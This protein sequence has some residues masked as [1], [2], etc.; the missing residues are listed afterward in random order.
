V[1]K[2]A[3]KRAAVRK[4]APKKAVVKKK[5]PPRAPAVRRREK[6]QK[7]RV[8]KGV[9]AG[10]LT[11]EEVK[12][13]REGGKEIRE[14]KKEYRSDGVV[15]KEERKDLHKSLNE[16]SKQ[17]AKEKHDTEVRGPDTPANVKKR[18][19]LGTGAAKRKPHPK[20]APGVRRRQVVQRRRI[21][22]GIKYGSLTKEEV[23]QLASRSRDIQR[24]KAEFKGDGALTVDERKQLHTALN[25]LS[26]DIFREK[27]DQDVRG[28]DTPRNIVWRN[29]LG[30]GAVGRPRARHILHHAE[31]LT[32]LK[33][34]LATE[35]LS[36][37]E[38]QDLENQFSES[39][40]EVFE[41]EE[42]ESTE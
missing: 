16:Q 8:A 24:M 13:I 28:P 38:R 33:K 23:K 27:H 37:E 36:A 4:A 17:I 41:M 42:S 35:E 39:M 40:G 29:R 22:K 30:T 3:V 31:R 32:R 21:A 26:R 1:R 12:G 7:R 34:R 18:N 2:Q 19:I 5:L 10:S 6:V 11:R 25:E 15:T 20:R 9:K 14:K